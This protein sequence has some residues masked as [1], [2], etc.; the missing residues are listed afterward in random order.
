[1]F[2]LRPKSELNLIAKVVSK[3]VQRLRQR[4]AVPKPNAALGTLITSQY[5]SYV[6]MLNLVF[7]CTW[8][9]TGDN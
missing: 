1:M 7:D 8:R 5:P 3:Y 2:E 6:C 9:V 4:I